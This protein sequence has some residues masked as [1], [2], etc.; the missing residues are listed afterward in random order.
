ML[1]RII[2]Q[3]FIPEQ[4]DSLDRRDDFVRDVKYNAGF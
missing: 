2:G 1:I 3:N 4:V